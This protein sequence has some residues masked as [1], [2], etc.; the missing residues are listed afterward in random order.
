M[1]EIAFAF[2]FLLECFLVSD[3]NTRAVLFSAINITGSYSNLYHIVLTNRN[4]THFMVHLFVL[5]WNV[6][7]LT[8][9]FELESPDG[10][11]AIRNIFKYNYVKVEDYTKSNGYITKKK[12]L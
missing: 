2:F 6:S 10:K 4:V 7:A 3:V 1:I 8:N 11:K 12:T 5:I 9:T